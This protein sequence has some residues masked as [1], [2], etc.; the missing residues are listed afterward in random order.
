MLCK[1]CTKHDQVN[2]IASA[3]RK[4]GVKVEVSVAVSTSGLTYFYNQSGK[5][6]KLLVPF[7]KG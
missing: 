7:A 2:K 4:V 1:V 5:G 6:G 3:M